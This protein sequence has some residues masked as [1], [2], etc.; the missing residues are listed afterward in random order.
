VSEIEGFR[1]RLAYLRW[2]RNAGRAAPETDEELAREW[3]V[4]LQWLRKWKRRADSPEGR[5][6]E[7]AITTALGEAVARWL[8]DGVGNAPDASA[9]RVWSEGA[10][11]LILRVAEPPITSK[12][13]AEFVNEELAAS[14]AYDAERATTPPAASPARGGAKKAAGGTKGRSR[15]R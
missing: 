14:R 5:R 15:G 2:L 9:R 8:Y 13:I 11:T 6:E 10:A 4:G 12:E 7:K 1:D 3:G